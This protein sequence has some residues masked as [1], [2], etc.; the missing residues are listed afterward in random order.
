MR[1]FVRH[2]SWLTLLV[3][4]SS[5]TNEPRKPLDPTKPPNPS[6]AENQNSAQKATDTQ[7]P[8]SASELDDDSDVDLKRRPVRNKLANIPP[9]CFT[10]TQNPDGNVQNPCYV[11]HANADV[12]NYQSQPE[13]QL[14]YA[15]PSVRRTAKVR[16]DWSNL[17]QDRSATVLAIPDEEVLSYVRQD[18]YH[19]ASGQIDLT[20]R[21]TQLPKRWDVNGDG[22]WNGY[23][24]DAAFQFNERGF[25]Q[26][27]RG[28]QTGWR[29]FAYVPFPGAFMP[30]NGSFDDVLIRLPEAFRQREDG[31]FDAQIYTVNLAIVESLVR[32]SDIAIDAIDEQPLQVDLDRNGKLGNATR[33]AYD[34]A[35][36]EKRFM[37]Y[38]GRARVEQQANRV[39]AAAGL[40][41]EGTEFLH[42]VRYLDVSKDGEA[43]PA[44]RMKEL[45]YA[46]KKRWVTYSDL[47]QQAFLEGKE[48]SLSPDAPEE[49]YGD[50]ERGLQS[51]LGWVYQGFIE[52]KAGRLRPQTQEESQ[53]CLGCHGGLSATDDTIFSWSRKLTTGPARGYYHWGDQPFR[54]QPD[55]MRRDG[56]PEFATY[57]KNNRAGDEYCE[58]TEVYERFFDDKGRPRTKAFDMLRTDLSDLMLPSR[59][60]ALSLDKAYWSIVR[61]QSF[62]RGRDPLLRP[63]RNVWQEIM[64]DESTGIKQPVPAP[65]L[66]VR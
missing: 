62:T 45:R 21:L 55:P 3:L 42:S 57:L 40:F 5:C 64:Q 7:P 51:K 16:N 32:R 27:A 25:D 2:A 11:C 6:H 20:Q 50:P 44:A 8:A 35:P 54:G 56:Q 37:S 59:E 52:D 24:P 43:Q 46:R 29:S 19:D 47:R 30:T 18:N 12:P 36:L 61:E 33:V 48:K 38:V 15:F 63:A 49:Y 34:W 66:A 23:V 41:P 53:F 22:Q 14:S 1:H 58:N 39:H 9:Q 13:N 28:Q 31:M 26:D 4:A 17:F 65:R 60:R 10:R